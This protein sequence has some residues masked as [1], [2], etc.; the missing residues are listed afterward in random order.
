MKI[1]KIISLLCLLPLVAV[2]C[3]EDETTLG[4]AP[5]SDIIIEEGTIAEEYNIYR[6]EELIISP[7]IN[8]KNA[9]K[10]LSYSWEIN[11]EEYSAEKDFRYVGDKL[12]SYKCRLVVENEDG[13]A[14]HPFVLNVNS[15]YE[16]GF[17]VI[18]CEEDGTSWLSFKKTALPGE[19][20]EGFFDYNCLT[21]NNP[22]MKFASN[23]SDIVQSSGRLMVSCKGANSDDDQPSIYFL[24]EKTLVVENVMTLPGYPEFVPS[25]ICVPP[26]E[27]VGVTYPI[28][29]ENGKVYEFSTT[30][31]QLQPSTVW[32]ASYA[33][34]RVVYGNASNRFDILLWD[35]DLGGIRLYYNGYGPYV[36]NADWDAVRLGEQPAS[37]LNYFKGREFASMTLIRKTKE[38]EKASN[39][40]FVIVTTKGKIMYRNIL[41]TGFWVTDLKTYETVLLNN[42]KNAGFG[43][44]PF[45]PTTPCIANDTYDSFLYADGNKVYRWY[46]ASNQLKTVD[47]LSTIGS[48]DAVI[49]AFEM[50]DDHKLTYVAFYEPGQ[51]GKN[52][53][54]WAID[55]DKGTVVEKYDNISYR[56]VKIIYKK[57]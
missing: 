49:T 16:E 4:D 8:Q 33:Q 32:R 48:D 45:G 3:F 25:M 9:V 57:K 5:I 50:S 51:S 23:I 31:G 2:S 54:V 35:N 37:E 12:G 30:E 10:P 52:G 20:V 15:P 38:Q 56:P 22:D 29:C 18:S 14:Y 24:N 11:L 21:V 6:N 40:E 39:P 46:Y 1:Y 41:Y 34:S 17:A 43:T 55:T 19:E 27:S 53:S 36:C 26:L 42:E 13:K 7:V 47:V 28:L 44:P